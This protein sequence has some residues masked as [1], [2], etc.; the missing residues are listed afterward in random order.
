MKRTI[1]GILCGIALFC[2]LAGNVVFALWENRVNN[3]VFGASAAPQE[4]R[5]ELPVLMYHH[6]LKDTSRTGEFVITPQQFERDLCYL[7]EK[8]YTAIGFQDIIDFQEGVRP[9]PQKPVLITFDDGYETFYAYAYPM[10]QKYQDR[11]A[12]M[13][14]GKYT[15]LYSGDVI[16]GLSYSHLNWEELKEMQQS[17]LVE[18][19]N[20]T[21]GLHS[22]DTRQGSQKLDSETTEQYQQMLKGDVGSLNHQIASELGTVPLAFAYPFGKI[23]AE[24]EPVLQELGFRI[25]LTCEQKMNYLE[26]TGEES[27]ELIRLGR[28]NRSG[29]Y[30]TEEFFEK[31]GMTG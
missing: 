29:L 18:V 14:I 30:S 22:L 2:I 16:K 8:G 31:I 11:A 23:S 24:S 5:V 28:F 1:T 17:Q 10:L 13:I 3:L 15:D 9:L 26:Q 12:V 27:Q 19:G 6:I 4:T 25:V 21:Y 20:H 7:R